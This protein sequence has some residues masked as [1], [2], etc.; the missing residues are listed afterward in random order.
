MPPQLIKIQNTTT[1]EIRLVDP[2][3]LDLP[4][5]EP[6]SSQL[7]Q[8][9]QGFMQG[10]K[11]A[12][13]AF[14]ETM[15]GIIPTIQLASDVLSGNREEAAP[16][17]GGLVGGFG[18]AALG[19]TLGGGAGGLAS[20]PFGPAAP[21]VAAYTI[22]AGVA[23]G[24]YLGNVLGSVAGESIV[25]DE[26]M[27]SAEDV[28]YAL[29]QGTVP[30][31]GVKMAQKG[32]GMMFGGK[33]HAAY[34]LPERLEQK[35][36]GA[37][38]PQ[39]KKSRSQTGG[40][41]PGETMLGNAIRRVGETGVFK[42][43]AGNPSGLMQKLTSEIQDL[44]QNRILPEIQRLESIR[45]QKGIQLKPSFTNTEKLIEQ[46][47]ASGEKSAVENAAIQRII[48]IEKELG[49]KKDTMVG[50]NSSRRALNKL[51]FKQND[52]KY[53]EEVTNA[54][55]QD[56]RESQLRHA[57]QLDP[58]TTLIDDLQK[59]ADRNQI[60]SKVL[61]PQT[62]TESGSIPKPRDWWRTTGGFGV[63]ILAGTMTG[64]PL[65]GVAALGADYMYNNPKGQLFLADVLRGK[66][67]TG[68]PRALGRG[69]VTM[70]ILGNQRQQTE[71]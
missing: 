66:P 59:S 9:G 27:P 58:N 23:L 43:Y 47:A 71:E 62:I 12:P 8:M 57:K 22:P 56:I 34:S 4:Q 64:S 2:S 26:G 29:G 45:Q 39:L 60:V 3:E 10:V 46:Y 11:D 67:I 25:R 30:T 65:A 20:L 24:G 53:L 31:F 15:G 35:A 17:L 42:E 51:V 6:F 50:L 18:G 44:E 32:L 14:V 19:G 69:S 48:D 63:P 52:P 1:G 33:G 40:Y 37:S 36:I 49:Q 55:R 38:I 70:Q 41:T 61:E 13:R 16:A 28:G 68:L 21:A 7:G 5:E 54:I